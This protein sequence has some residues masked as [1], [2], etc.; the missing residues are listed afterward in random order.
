MF[1]NNQES[2]ILLQ[3]VQE[4]YASQR[5]LALA[6]GYS[7]G[8][9]NKSLR[10][11]AEEGLIAD[12][13]TIT[14]K[15]KEL[16]E[17]MKPKNAVILAAG[18]GMRMAPINVMQPKGMLEVRGEPLVERL[19]K[20]LN[21]VGI[22]DITLVVGFM[23]ERFDY[24]VDAY[25]VRLV[26]NG[27]YAAKNNL[28]SMALSLGELGN[29]YVVPCD[30]WCE[31]NPFNKN[32]LGSWYMVSDFVDDDSGVRVNRN[33]QL[34]RVKDGVDGNSMVGISY[35]AGDVAKEVAAKIA[36][37]ASDSSRDADFWEEALY[38]GDKMV[39][40]ARIVPSA[41][42]AEINT[43]E[44]L[45]ELD[46]GSSQL[47][48]DAIDT[49]CSVFDV[50]SS[51]VTGI[52]VLKKGMT[53]RSFLFC[54]HGSKYI[55]R[56]P[57][58]G[59]DQLIDR[60]Q[61]AEVYKAIA[62]KGLCDEP[63][64]INPTNGYKITKYL[65]GVRVCDTQNDDD[66]TRCMSVLKAFH[67]MR[68][69]VPHTFDVFEKTEYYESLWNGQP[70]EYRDY[71]LTKKNVFSLRDYVES[72]PHDWCLTHIDAVPDNFL[73]H[74][75]A[76]GSEALQLTD[77]EYSGM[78]DPH[79]D[80]AMFI[81]YSLYDK[82]QADHLIDLYFADD[83]GCSDATRAK[84]YCYVAMCGLL[85]SNWCE[86]K[87]NIGVE[88]GEYSLAQYRYGKDYYRYAKELI[89]N[90]TWTKGRDIGY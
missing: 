50:S 31:R 77:W 37:M 22:S 20:Q 49:I 69:Q 48:S 33:G 3:L 52:E 51:E 35:L 44:Q 9:V 43:Y 87:R 36:R 11:L 13:M 86:Y 67:K 34:V 6:T 12:N 56:I 82:G 72:Q 10:T 59:T 39:V 61:E 38:E 58:E 85:W 18:Y 80:I 1:M 21:E 60:V 63:V 17:E 75:A 66:L 70:S 47:K 79:V 54:I 32:E 71:S 42:V 16:L 55:M 2:H 73:F 19:I 46:E 68:L 64:Y 83:G 81:I 14:K 57:G 74:A 88:F 30:V 8:M 23:K 84:I 25:G 24:L 76:D 26:V 40:P 27:D 15:A 5:M 7:L 62:G 90:R 41:I 45:R 29:T 65:E 78:Q 53:N 89:K 4:P 28:S